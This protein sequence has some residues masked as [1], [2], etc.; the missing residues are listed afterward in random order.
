[1]LAPLLKNDVPSAR[2]GECLSNWA[3]RLCP[4]GHPGKLVFLR[5]TQL[6]MLCTMSLRILIVDDS[7]TTRRILRAIV[8]SREW[9]VCGEAEDG[10][11]GVAKFEE[12]KPDLVLIDLA[13]PDINGL[14]AAKS[15]SEVDPTVPLVLF[16]VLDMPELKEPARTAGITEVVSKAQAWSLVSTIERVVAQRSAP[17]QP[18]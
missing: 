5:Y 4:F 13:M 11:S 17:N 3:E 18:H 9:T 6:R 16:T 1:V 8:H 10:R 2:P 14:E 7:E 12:L 15:M